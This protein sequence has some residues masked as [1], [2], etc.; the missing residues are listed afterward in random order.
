MVLI[1]GGDP[2]RHWEFG[3]SAELYAAD[4]FQLSQLVNKINARHRLG[5]MSVSYSRGNVGEILK[6]GETG[7]RPPRERSQTS[8]GVH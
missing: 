5:C 7:L 6:K 4:L 2:S 1:H 3:S 8:T